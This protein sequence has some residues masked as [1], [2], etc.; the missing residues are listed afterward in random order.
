MIELPLEK[1][2]GVPVAARVIIDG[3]ASDFVGAETVGLELVEVMGNE[4]AGGVINLK[5][6]AELAVMVG[7]KALRV[8][9]DGPTGYKML[10][11]VVKGELGTETELGVEVEVDGEGGICPNKD[12]IMIEVAMLFEVPDIGASV[13]WI[14]VVL[15][16][17]IGECVAMVEATLNFVT[18]NTMIGVMVLVLGSEPKPDGIG[19]GSEVGEIAEVAGSFSSVEE[20]GL[21]NDQKPGVLTADAEKRAGGGFFGDSTGIKIVETMGNVDDTPVEITGAGAGEVVG[22]DVAEVSNSFSGDEVLGETTRPGKYVAGSL[23]EM[24]MIGQ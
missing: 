11:F 15:N 1:E 7:L 21:D 3:S 6:N 10:V 18:V 24:T 20:V 14:D 9:S 2:I 17:N 4:S 13:G 5:D 8:D 12:N 22:I 16:I 23:L 19:I